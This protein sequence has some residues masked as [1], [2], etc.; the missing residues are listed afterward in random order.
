LERVRN[1]SNTLWFQKTSTMQ[2]YDDSTVG[3]LLYP[4]KCPNLKLASR[5]GWYLPLLHL[6]VLLV[7]FKERGW[8]RIGP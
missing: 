4:G 6:F 2:S 3:P 5:V 8:I 1:C 7:Q